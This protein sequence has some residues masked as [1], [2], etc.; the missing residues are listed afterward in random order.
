MVIERS[1][2]RALRVIGWWLLIP[3]LG[4]PLVLMVTVA[5]WHDYFKIMRELREALGH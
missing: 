5:Y 3:V 4:P 1:I 2:L